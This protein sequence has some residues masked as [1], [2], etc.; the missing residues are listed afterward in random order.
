MKQ[1]GIVREC[2]HPGKPHKHGSECYRHDNCRCALGRAYHARK[3][4]ER[5]KAKA[6]GTFQLRTTDA[7]G[8]RRRLEAL[9]TLGYS[10]SEIGAGAGLSRHA[11]HQVMR[12]RATR[13]YRTNAAAIAAFYDQHWDK[14]APESFASNYVQR[15]AA[16]RGYAPPLAWDDDTIEDPK[17]KPNVTAGEEVIDWQAIERAIKHSVKGSRVKL[18]KRERQAAIQTMAL[19]GATATEIARRLG[20][21]GTMAQ[22][23]V[24]EAAA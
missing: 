12:E 8:T 6:L 4:A 19:R 20:V 11:I 2:E 7:T 21:S 22:Q 10:S 18:T 24:Q 23:A 14:P 16:K 15:L 1:P 9:M 13:V 17:A 5:R 3:A